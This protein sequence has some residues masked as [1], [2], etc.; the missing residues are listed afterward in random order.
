LG[1]LTE[2]LLGS[3]HL[4]WKAQVQACFVHVG[5]LAISTFLG[6]LGGNM[7]A[8]YRKTFWGMQIPIV[9]TALTILASSQPWALAL[10][11]FATMQV[12]AVLG[13]FL[14]YRLNKKLGARC[15]PVTLR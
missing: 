13:G 11:F 10:L 4:W 1:Y 2:H 6:V 3:V 9:G 14:G 8:H 5:D 12:S 7:W 15:L